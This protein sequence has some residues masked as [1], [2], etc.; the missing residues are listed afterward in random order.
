MTDRQLRADRPS[1]FACAATDLSSGPGALDDAAC[2]WTQFT[3]DADVTTGR[4]HWTIG[5]AALENADCEGLSQLTTVGGCWL[6]DCS[7]LDR[8]ISTG[9]SQLE[10]QETS[11]RISI[12][13]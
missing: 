7:A 1:G 4:T 2:R 6:S 5:C 9:L 8:F 13:V 12:S 10:A 11:T 3:N